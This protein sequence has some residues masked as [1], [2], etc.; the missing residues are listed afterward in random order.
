MCTLD[1]FPLQR[2]ISQAAKRARAL[3]E[4]VTSALCHRGRA[5]VNSRHVTDASQI[6]GREKCLRC[7]SVFII[8]RAFLRRSQVFA[9]QAVCVSVNGALKVFLFVGKKNLVWRRQ[10]CLLASVRALHRTCSRSSHS[11]R[12]RAGRWVMTSEW[13]AQVVEVLVGGSGRTCWRP[14]T[15]TLI[16]KRVTEKSARRV[17]IVTF[18]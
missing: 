12:W 13:R 18:I 11:L 16:S 9:L 8:T 6:Q 3:C 5:L 4:L 14:L 15:L 17:F 2:H 1:V 10:F 7:T